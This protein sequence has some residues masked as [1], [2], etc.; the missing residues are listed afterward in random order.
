[1]AVTMLGADECQIPDLL[2]YEFIQALTRVNYASNLAHI[3][4][5]E[6]MV[7][8]APEG[9][10]SVVGGNWRIFDEMVKA[11]HATFLPN[12]SVTAIDIEEADAPSSGQKYI[13]KTQSSGDSAAVEQTQDV[14]F[15]DVVVA[16]PYQFSKITTSNNVLEDA[17]DEIPYI[18]LHVTIFTSPFELSPAYFKVSPEKRP[19]TVLTTLADGEGP[20]SGVQGAGKAGFYSISTLRRVGNPRTGKLEYLYKIFSPERVTPELLRYAVSLCIHLLSGLSLTDFQVI[21]SESRSQILSSEAQSR[22]PPMRP[23]SPSRG[24]THTS[25]NHTPRGFPALPSKTLSSATGYTTLQVCG[26]SVLQY[27]GPTT[28][29]TRSSQIRYGELHLHHGDQRSDGKECGAPDH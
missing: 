11:S 28:V 3:H 2:S 1:M 22:R 6:T 5:L 24:T 15:D 12:T 17:I 8:T 9:A 23:S 25:S 21:S 10:M 27:E 26:L 20:T 18:T 19:A 7:S 29:L 14:A 16:T 4:G 13:L